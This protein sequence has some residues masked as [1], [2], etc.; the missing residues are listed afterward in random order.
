[1]KRPYICG[2]MTGCENNNYDR[3]SY[4]LRALRDIG[5]DPQSPHLLEANIPNT[6]KVE[7]D[8]GALYRMVIPGDVYMLSTCDSAIAL[9]GWKYSEGTGFEL[10]AARLFR[11][12]I[13]TRR[14]PLLDQLDGLTDPFKRWVDTLIKEYDLASNASHP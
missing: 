2:P 6:A 10:S 1:M 3:F 7:M 8:K 4:L 12:P 13:V 5:L 9:P 11:Q 14:D